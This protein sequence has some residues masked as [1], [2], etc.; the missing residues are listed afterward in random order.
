MCVSWGDGMHLCIP[1]DVNTNSGIN[2][3]FIVTEKSESY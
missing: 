2:Y 3:E 1:Y